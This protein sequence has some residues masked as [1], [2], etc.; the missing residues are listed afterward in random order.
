MTYPPE[1][2]AGFVKKTLHVP[3]KDVS[4]ETKRIAGERLEKVFSVLPDKIV[5]LFMTGDRPLTIRILPDT[6]LPVGMKTSSMEHG[7]GPRYEIVVRDEHVRF[8]EDLF[9]ASMLRELGHV[10]GEIPPEAD[11]P[12]TRGDRARFKESLECRAD[13][14]VWRWGLRHYSMRYLTA[15]FPEHWVERIVEDIGKMLLTEDR[16]E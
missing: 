2:I 8:P 10:V 9:I 1:E 16:P 6:G 11:W 5:E 13:A 15:T 4:N 3:G 12:A 14:M 7:Q